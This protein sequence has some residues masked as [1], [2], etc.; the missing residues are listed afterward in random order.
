M[1]ILPAATAGEAESDRAFERLAAS[2][3]RETRRE[4]A[5]TTARQSAERSRTRARA[6][7]EVRLHH[8]EEG[9]AR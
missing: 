8:H 6:V 4:G 7:H 5:S 2:S 1:T 3:S 9:V